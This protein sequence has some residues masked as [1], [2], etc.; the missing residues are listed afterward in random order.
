MKQEFRNGPS[1]WE[2]VRL[3]LRATRARS[4]GRRKR[5]QELLHQRGGSDWGGFGYTLA[6]LFMGV[7]NVGA[8]FVVRG[9][10]EAGQRI[11]AERKGKIVVSRSFFEG[12]EQAKRV[13]QVEGVN[14]DDHLPES[15]YSSEAGRIAEDHGGD[16]KEIESKL[17]NAVRDGRTGDF[18]DDEV[19][20]PGF[21]AL[22][23]SGP[24]AATLGSIV[25]LWWWLMLIFQ[26]EGA[27]L[28]LQRRRHPMWEWL[29]SHPVQPGAVFMAEML[30][31]IA[32][33]PVYWTAPL[34]VGCLYGFAY[35]AE[36]AFAAVILIGIPITI[37][38]AC[39]GKALEIGVILRFSP[40]SRGAIIGLMGWMGYTSLMLFFLGWFMAG[41]VMPVLAKLLGFLV[42]IPWPWLQLFLGATG[43][44]FSFM[45]GVTAC[46]IFSSITLAGAVWFSVWGGGTRAE[47]KL[48]AGRHGS[49]NSRC[50]V[51]TRASL[52]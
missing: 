8:A 22:S 13:S 46:G 27:E 19:A 11:L 52:S 40:R 7:L 29:F 18:I 41:K 43:N 17:R 15:F 38:A 14:T 12:V 21:A 36:T 10:V 42:V 50:T 20:A 16:R 44:S 37:S 34:F 49:S 31:P 26:G 51:R 6:I 2:T 1:F 45:A 4:A 24:L 33:N 25:L 28:D 3:L 48:G 5:Q 30:S 39:L 35:D 32:A 47:R 9:A 23:R